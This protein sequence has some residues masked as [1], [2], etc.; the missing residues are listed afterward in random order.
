MVFCSVEPRAMDA[1]LACPLRYQ[2][3]YQA[4]DTNH[5]EDQGQ[6][7]KHAQQKNLHPLPIQG[8]LLQIY[9]LMKA[10]KRESRISLRQGLLHGSG[11]PIN[12]AM[13]A[14]N[15]TGLE[16]D[17][18]H[19]QRSLVSLR[20]RHVEGRLR[21]EWFGIG[22]T[23]W[24]KN[25]A[26]N[27]NYLVG[28][29]FCAQMVADGVEA[30][31]VP[32]GKSEIHNT[33]WLSLG[34]I[35]LCKGAAGQHRNTKRGEVFWRNVNRIADVIDRLAANIQEV[36]ACVQCA[37]IR[38]AQSHCCRFD[39]GDFFH[40]RNAVTQEFL[41]GSSIVVAGIVQGSL[42]GQDVARIEARWERL[43]MNEGTNQQSCA[44]QQDNSKS[45]LCGNQC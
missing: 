2:I 45:D 14:D 6:R 24:M 42:C 5:G 10:R 35:V 31:Q 39:P 11:Q 40:G 4:V 16:P 13:R 19:V 27:S 29:I 23:W 33:D 25:I 3:R 30:I 20:C 21:G 41:E 17:V 32:A 9:H 26:H 12:R 38:K 28:D 15:P 18:I 37:L 7:G 36:H 43:K 1:N 34:G 22:N 8:L 44:R